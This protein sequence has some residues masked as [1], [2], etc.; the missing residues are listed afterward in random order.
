MS[1]DDIPSVRFDQRSVGEEEESLAVV[2]VTLPRAGCS[3][4]NVTQKFSILTISSTF[5]GPDDR[6]LGGEQGGEL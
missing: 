1:R 4:T 2:P 6:S 3:P 5:L